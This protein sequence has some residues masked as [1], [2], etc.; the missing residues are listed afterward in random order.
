MATAVI[1]NA[2]PTYFT[3]GCF[4]GGCTPTAVS[5]IA[6]GGGALVF[7]GQTPF[8]LNTTQGFSAAQMGNFTFLG[9]PTG[10]LIT[11]FT[12][13]VTQTVPGPTGTG[14]FT[15]LL[16]GVITL[17]GSTGN[18]NFQSPT[19]FV[20]NG[21]R[22]TLTNLGGPG[23]TTPN[24]LVL[25]PPGEQTSVQSIVTPEAVPEPATLLL[26]GSGLAGLGGYLR[27]LRR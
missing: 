19:T 24:S 12:L 15:A 5:S 16:S 3:Q 10:V 6:V 2:D 17:G 11:P 8:G 7:T 26:F 23:A 18:V 21:Y 20:I 4:G 27:R 13:L 25:N 9:T 22:Y 14:T 1:T